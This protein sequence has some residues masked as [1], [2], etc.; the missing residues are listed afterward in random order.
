MFYTLILLVLV[1]TNLHRFRPETSRTREASSNNKT[2]KKNRTGENHRDLPMPAMTA[3]AEA[4]GHNYDEV[5]SDEQ[6]SYAESDDNKKR[7]INESALKTERVNSLLLSEISECD[8]SCDEEIYSEPIESIEVCY[9]SD[10][11]ASYT[12]SVINSRDIES[13][14]SGVNTESYST[15]ANRC[16]AQNSNVPKIHCLLTAPTKS[17]APKLSTTVV[18]NIDSETRSSVRLKARVGFTAEENI[19]SQ[20]LLDM[21]GDDAIDPVQV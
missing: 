1:G 18:S 3:A 7:C 10:N 19:R 11:K 14:L 13:Q 21:V 4:E 20:G 2:K 5:Q 8:I 15:F 9:T 6:Y 12:H 16:P 17:E